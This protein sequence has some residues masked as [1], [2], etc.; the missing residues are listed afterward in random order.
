MIQKPFRRRKWKKG[1]YRRN[2]YKDMFEEN[3]KKFKEKD[4][5]KVTKIQENETIKNLFSLSIM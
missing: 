3:L 4:I 1:R 2:S 5:E